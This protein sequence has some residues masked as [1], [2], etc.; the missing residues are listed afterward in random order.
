MVK[1]HRTLAD[2]KFAF[3]SYFKS[4]FI[5]LELLTI[6]VQHLPLLVNTLLQDPSL[7]RCLA[8]LNS[9]CL[10]YLYHPLVLSETDYTPIFFNEH[11]SFIYSFIHSFSRNFCNVGKYLFFFFFPFEVLFLGLLEI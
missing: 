8:P 7:Q 1:R 9:C 10:P 4:L 5:Y 2:L 6:L 11:R 3:I